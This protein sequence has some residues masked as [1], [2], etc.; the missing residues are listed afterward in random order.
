MPFL[1]RI[2][3]YLNLADDAI[4]GSGDFVPTRES[5]PAKKAEQMRVPEQ[6]S[7]RQLARA[8]NSLNN[9]LLRQQTARRSQAKRPPER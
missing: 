4:G 8:V 3:H 7:R 5:S 6:E 9:W 2:H 1:G